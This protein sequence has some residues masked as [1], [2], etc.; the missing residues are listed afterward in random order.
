MMFSSSVHLSKLLS[1][2]MQHGIIKI[3]LLHCMHSYLV[4]LYE[5][6]LLYCIIYVF[7]S[8]GFFC[9]L[10][11]TMLKFYMIKASLCVAGIGFQ[12]SMSTQWSCFWGPTGSSMWWQLFYPQQLCFAFFSQTPEELEDVSDLED[13]HEVRSHTSIQTEGKTDR[14]SHL[15]RDIS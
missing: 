2:F 6:I 14:V 5:Q 1:P 4:S 3:H 11:M 13:D 10:S 8:R 7:F 9:F 15:P 12:D